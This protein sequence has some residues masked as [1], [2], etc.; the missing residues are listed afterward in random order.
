MPHEPTKTTA[1]GS[2]SGAPWL[3]WTYPRHRY[4]HSLI[5]A[6]ERVQ[7]RIDLLLD[8][9]DEAFAQDDW[10]R[11]GDRARRALLLDPENRDAINFLTAAERAL[12]DS[13]E[14]LS[15][16]QAPAGPPLA[17]PKAA[18]IEPT[19]FANARY[20][21]KRFLGEDGKK[22]VYLAHYEPHRGNLQPD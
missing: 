22:R 11:V 17:P 20:Q 2:L 14:A 4:Y 5:M 19:S 1:Q 7:R 18:P 15:E 16:A 3:D 13:G 9:A 8:E 6:S 21:V 12:S 10:S